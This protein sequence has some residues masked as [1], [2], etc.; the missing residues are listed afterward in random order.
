M[1]RTL[2][3]SLLSA[4]LLTSISAQTTP[5]FSGTWTMDEQQSGSP[6]H[7][8][9]QSPVVWVIRQTPTTLLVD[10]TRGERSTTVTYPLLQGNVRARQGAEPPTNRAYWDGERLVTETAHNISGQT[11]TVREVRT[12]V[13]EGREMVV[14]RVVE[15]E[16]GYTMRGAQNFSIVRD[17]FR[18]TP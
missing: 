3:V 9:F 5:D 14:E 13:N 6:G 2:A 7:E 8:G 10:M 17:V 11:V 1:A 15:V 4:A 18:R 16:H 12:L